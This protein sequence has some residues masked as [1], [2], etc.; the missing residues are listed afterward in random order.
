MGASG[1]V[2]GS[3]QQPLLTG[4]AAAAVTGGSEYRP[5]RIS[6]S[7]QTSVGVNG[8]GSRGDEAWNV[9]YWAGGGRRSLAH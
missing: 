6:G 9:N 8:A 4:A 3:V 2:F 7:C 5:R 1:S